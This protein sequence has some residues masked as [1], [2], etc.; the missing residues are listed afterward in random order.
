M[1]DKW[2]SDYDVVAFIDDFGNTL[3]VGFFLRN[4]LEEKR[5]S[6]V[7]EAFCSFLKG[8]SG[9]FKRLRFEYSV[10]G[11]F[12]YVTG[13]R[14]PFLKRTS[15]TVFGAKRKSLKTVFKSF[16]FKDEDDERFVEAI[17]ELKI[18]S[19]KKRG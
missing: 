17:K 19:L 5:Y 1:C 12:Y 11:K 6:R 15:L 9:E 4:V 16:I 2:L 14:V 13:V 10:N 8:F 3:H 7:L 18:I